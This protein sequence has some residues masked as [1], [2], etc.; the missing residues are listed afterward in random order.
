[1][2][3]LAL[4][5]GAARGIGAAT[6]TE[7]AKEGYHVVLTD[8]LI[9]QGQATAAAIVA[10]GGRAEFHRQDVA[11]T[12][13][14]NRV[15]AA[16]EARHGAFELLV[17]NAGFVNPKALEQLTDAEWD[18]VLDANLK[19]MLR[20]CRAA[21]PAMKV[22]KRGNIVCLSS[23]AGYGIGWAGTLAYSSSKA[24][25]AG[26]VKTLA[27][28][29]GPFNIRVNGIAPSGL[30]AKAEDVPLRRVGQPKDIA[31]AVVLLASDR[32]SYITGQMLSVD[33]GFSIAL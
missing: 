14:T 20:V 33:G 32:A 27:A 25:I 3:K 12:D 15:I 1:M 24:G 28:E 10:A 5:T 22:A 9:E 30:H 4:V 8:I 17:N 29:L 26:F 13:E 7:L 18:K 19:G 11:N 16:A 2:T 6:A 21:V 23:I 31:D